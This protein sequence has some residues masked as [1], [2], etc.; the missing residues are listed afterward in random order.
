MS[1][2]ANAPIFILGHVIS[3]RHEISHEILSPLSMIGLGVNKG[4]NSRQ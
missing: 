1:V 3:D 2:M 4:P